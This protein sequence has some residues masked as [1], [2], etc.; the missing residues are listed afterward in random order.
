MAAC[1]VGDVSFLCFLE[2]GGSAWLH[3]R[4]SLLEWVF[5]SKKNGKKVVIGMMA[6]VL[7]VSL[8]ALVIANKARDQRREVMESIEAAKLQEANSQK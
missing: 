7:L 1:L 6:A 2:D 8:V 4:A 5:M 3:L